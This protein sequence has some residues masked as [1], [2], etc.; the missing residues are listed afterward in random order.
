PKTPS[1][2]PSPTRNV[3]PS[4]ITDVERISA[5]PSTMSRPPQNGRVR[6]QSRHAVRARPAPP[7]GVPGSAV[8]TGSPPAPVAQGRSAGAAAEVQMAAAQPERARC[9]GPRDLMYARDGDRTGLLAERADLT[10]LAR[11]LGQ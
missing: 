8:V 1:T 11:R 2:P 6:R 3:G 7:V 10:G 9:R 5:P 4:D